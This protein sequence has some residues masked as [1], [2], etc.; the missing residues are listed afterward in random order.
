MMAGNDATLSSMGVAPSDTL[1][2]LSN[3]AITSL[4]KSCA[5][6]YTFAA[7]ARDASVAQPEHTHASHTHL[8]VPLVSVPVLPSQTSPQSHAQLPDAQPTQP[9]PSSP[10]PAQQAQPTHA[11]PMHSLPSHA[12]HASA[13]PAPNQ[14]SLLVSTSLPHIAAANI[15]TMPAPVPAMTPLP[16]V[17][18]PLVAAREDQPAPK[19]PRTHATHSQLVTTS[20]CPL[21]EET[22]PRQRRRLS[23]H[24]NATQTPPTPASACMPT[25]VTANMVEIGTRAAFSTQHPAHPTSNSTAHTPSASVRA[26][27]SASTSHLSSLPARKNFDPGG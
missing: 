16:H 24:G 9:T 8:P 19:R 14:P 25:S 20:Q 1:A 3:L 5:I 6:L 7:S 23:N 27:E 22:P 4:Q 26:P 18:Q 2:L 17:L 15:V 12:Q 11:Q 21:A 10:S 13:Q